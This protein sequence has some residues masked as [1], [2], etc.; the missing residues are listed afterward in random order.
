MKLPSLFIPHGAG[1][2]FFMRWTWGPEDMW[3]RLGLWLTS[4]ADSLPCRP[5]AILVF[6]AHWEADHFTLGGAPFPKLLYDYQG[7]PVETCQLRYQAPGAPWLA[8]E[9]NE[10]LCKAGLPASLDVQRGLDHGA[11]VPLK[12]IYPAADIP[13]F[14]LSL[15]RDL[16]P[17]AHLAAGEALAELRADGVLIVGSGMSFHNLQPTGSTVE[18]RAQ[19]FDDWLYDTLACAPAEGRLRLLNWEHA[20]EARFAH[21]RAEHLMPLLVACGAA[22]GQ[23]ARRVYAEK[24]A[25]LV[26]VSAYRFG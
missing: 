17:E 22:G 12:L 11:F 20:P 10:R 25:G 26:A 7:F 3:A 8:Y 4:I 23:P 19:A 18:I 21:P 9:A 15:L 16:D 24:L 6:S 5:K 1:P 14:P 2:C 13:V